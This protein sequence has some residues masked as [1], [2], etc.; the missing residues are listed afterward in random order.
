MNPC[1]CG[2]CY[3][4]TPFYDRLLREH[5]RRIPVSEAAVIWANERIAEHAANLIAQLEVELTGAAD[6][7]DGVA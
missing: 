5:L 7:E 4:P 1:D 2:E 3:E 6:A